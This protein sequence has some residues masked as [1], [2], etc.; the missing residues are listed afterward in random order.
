MDI[1][2][3]VALVTGASSGIGEATAL[4]LAAAGAKVGIAARRVDRL[5]TLKSA[6]E[7]NG[8]EALPLEMDVVDP[9]AVEAG[10]R[11]L[12]ETFGPIDILVS[13][14]GLLAASDIDQFKTDEWN[15]MVD[16]NLKGLFHATAAV[17]P[18]MIARKSGHVFVVSSLAGRRVMPDG[19]VV[20]SATKFAMTAFAEGLRMEVGKKHNIRVTNVQPGSVATELHLHSSDPEHS[21]MLASYGDELT[22]LQSAD[23][24]D[25]ILFAARAPERTNVAELFIMPTEQA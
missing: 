24:A 14:A 9:A 6:I 22:Q 2:G 5:Q 19:L 21:R 8:G 12:A 10:S 23:I 18:Q 11:R 1:A 16:I 3:K 4:K 7:R 20:Y 13:N 15:R 25:A 17:L